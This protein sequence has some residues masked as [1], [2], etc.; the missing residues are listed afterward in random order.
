MNS[1]EA[2]RVKAWLQYATEG[3]QKV[4]PQLEYA[5]LPDSVKT[6]AQARVDGL[7]CNGAAINGAS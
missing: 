7:Q 2:K 5:P 6:K 1:S 3:G 4:A